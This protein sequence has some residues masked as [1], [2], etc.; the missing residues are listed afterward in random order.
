MSTRPYVRRIDQPAPVTG[1]GSQLL[2]AQGE[3]L[4]VPVVTPPAPTGLTI[5]GTGVRFSAANPTGYANL[6]WTPGPGTPPR[7]TYQVQQATDSAFTANARTAPTSATAA[8]VDGAAGVEHWYRVRAV[9]DGTPSAWSNVVT[10]TL[11]QD[12]APPDPPTDLAVAFAA[13]GTL[14]VRATPPASANY[15]HMEVRV[16]DTDG[17]PEWERDSFVTGV[18]RWPP[19]RNKQR[20]SGVWARSVLVEVRSLSWAGVASAAVTATATMPLPATPTGLT[21]T[22]QADDG[23]AAAECGITWATVAGM[24]Y[25]LVV[26]AGVTEREVAG[27][28]LAYT[29]AMN[30]QD[31]GGAPDKQL[32][33]SLVAMDGLEQRSAPATLTA[34]NA[35]PPAAAISVYAGYNATIS[36]VITASPARDFKHFEVEVTRDGAVLAARAFTTTELLQ[37]YEVADGPGSYT[38]RARAVD[39]FLSPGAWSSPT[40]AVAL[41]PLTLASLRED[42]VYSDSPKTN[43]ATLK[44]VLADDIL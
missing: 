36:L 13:D 37:I 34:T 18:W 31:H 9:L 38:F 14:E 41:N 26:D 6:S 17:S 33:L 5:T 20:T 22:W 32:S 4:G 16:L 42:A 15:R 30:A 27:G 35:A 43:P 44:A 2:S 21:T 25:L 3:Q 12:S 40:A 8:S 7:T 24:R 29:L 23:T 28:S 11:P 1:G 19:A 10:A 39:A